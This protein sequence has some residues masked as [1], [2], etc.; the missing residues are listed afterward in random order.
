MA[1]RDRGADRGVASDE[2]SEAGMIDYGFD[3]VARSRQQVDG[4]G[5]IHQPIVGGPWRK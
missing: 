3:A 1:A 2:G 4:N 5:L